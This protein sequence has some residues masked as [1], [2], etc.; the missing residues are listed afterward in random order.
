MITFL[1]AL[2]T[3]IGIGMLLQGAWWAVVFFVLGGVFWIVGDSVDD[4]I[5]ILGGFFLWIFFGVC[6]YI[7]IKQAAIWITSL[8][9]FLVSISL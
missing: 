2:L 1:G 3:I 4:D 8:V 6:T 9:M 7:I 5:A